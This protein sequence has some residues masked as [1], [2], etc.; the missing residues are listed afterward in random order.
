MQILV[1]LSAY[2]STRNPRRLCNYHVR[3]ALDGILPKLPAHSFVFSFSFKEPLSSNVF[4]A[5]LSSP[6]T[7][8]AR[9]SYL[10]PTFFIHSFVCRF[11]SRPILPLLWSCLLLHLPPTTICGF[12][13]IAP[14]ILLGFT[15]I[16]A[17]TPPIMKS[18]FWCACLFRLVN[19][20]NTPDRPPLIAVSLSFLR[21]LFEV[22]PQAR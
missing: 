12:L 18:G 9:F 15:H 11:F 17:L 8:H 22:R 3:L 16:H 19:Y 5:R 13:R 20:A 4:F 21:V 7:S 10:T 14:R 6:F 1:V 2:A